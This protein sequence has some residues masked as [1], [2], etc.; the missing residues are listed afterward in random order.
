MLQDV[1]SRAREV[2]VRPS[3]ELKNPLIVLKP[4]TIEKPLVHKLK[5]FLCTS[6]RPM[7]ESLFCIVAPKETTLGLSFLQSSYWMNRLDELLFTTRNYTWYKDIRFKKRENKDYLSQEAQETNHCGCRNKH[8]SGLGNQRQLWRTFG[9]Q[10]LSPWKWGSHMGGASR[11]EIP[12]AVATSITVSRWDGDRAETQH[13]NSTGID[14][15]Q[16]LSVAFCWLC[17]TAE[18]QPENNGHYRSCHCYHHCHE[19]RHC[20]YHHHYHC[21]CRRCHYPHN[22]HCHL[23]LSVSSLCHCYDFHRFS[24]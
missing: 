9:P 16:R 12:K 21:C 10:G 23:F 13:G 11:N 15:H 18:F 22:C 17:S 2:K 6:K 19:S 8:T 14:W 7:P 3:Q 5:G 4:Q 24:S 1:A 20:H